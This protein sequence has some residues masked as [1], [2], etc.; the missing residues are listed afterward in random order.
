MEKIDYLKLIN[1]NIVVLANDTQTIQ[2][3]LW[4]WSI[5]QCVLLGLIL[6]KLW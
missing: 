6:W 5:V 3:T 4:F 1:K 2:L